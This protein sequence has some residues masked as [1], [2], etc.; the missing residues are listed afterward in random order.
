MEILSRAAACRL[1]IHCQGLNGRWQLASGKEGAAQVAD[2]L[3][4]VQIDTISVI[5]RVHN[6]VLGTRQRA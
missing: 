5:E 1:A 2:R 4:Y 3:G 6:H